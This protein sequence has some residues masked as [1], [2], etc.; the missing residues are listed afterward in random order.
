MKGLLYQSND[1]IIN[2]IERRTGFGEKLATY[3]WDLLQDVFGL[4]FSQESQVNVNKLNEKLKTGAGV[5]YINHTS[6]K[7]VPVV[8]SLIRSQL[9]NTK[10]LFGPVSMKHYDFRRRPVSAV[11]LRSLKLL[12]IQPLPIVQ[13]SDA[14]DY[15]EKRR[16]MLEA[17]K[18]ETENM[19]QP[20][21]VYGIAPEGTRNK[22]D[23]TLQ[24]ANRG[25][26]YLEQY[27]RE[28]HYLPL[29][30]MSKKHSDLFSVLAGEPL[31]LDNIIPTNLILPLDKKER[32]QT[33]ADLHMERMADLMP[34]ELR[35]VYTGSSFTS[36]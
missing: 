16:E 28:I 20:G 36:L 14:R 4:E 21:S 18:L 23:G 5:I 22:K 11:V 3:T 12:G 35:G 25:I 17:L 31:Q 15:G 10:Q 30:I 33:I 32:A 9:T 29:V 8:I 7:D 34:E 19:K 1:I 27:G 2:M 6:S 26:G 24:R 13:V